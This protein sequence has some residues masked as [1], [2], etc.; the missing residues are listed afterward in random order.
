MKLNKLS[1]AVAASLAA[2]ASGTASAIDVYLTSA[3]ALRDTMSRMVS[4]YCTGAPG[5]FRVTE[6]DTGASSDKDFRVYECTFKPSSG[7]TGIPALGTGV[8]GNGTL[9]LGNAVMRIF[10][11]VKVD[12]SLGGSIVGVMPIYRPID[13]QFVTPAGVGALPAGCVALAN[14]TIGTKSWPKA[15]CNTKPRRAPNASDPGSG[16]NGGVHIG[17]SDTRTDNYVGLNLANVVQT[18][19][20]FLL[21]TP[22]EITH[23]STA[24]SP[25][26]LTAAP[27]VPFIQLGFGI[28]VTD[29]L[30]TATPALTNLSHSQIGSIFSGAVDNWTEVGGPNEPVT[31]CRRTQGSGTQASWNA[32]ANDYPCKANA[33]PF[34][35]LAVADQFSTGSGLHEGTGNHALEVIENAGT[36]DVKKCLNDAFDAGKMALGILSLENNESN[37]GAGKNWQFVALDGVQ[38]FD[39]GETFVNTVDGVV[40]RIR[41]ERMTLGNYNYSQEPTIQWRT[42]AVNGLP[43]APLAQKAFGIVLRDNA[44]TPGITTKLPGV[45]SLPKHASATVSCMTPTTGVSSMTRDGNVCQTLVRSSCL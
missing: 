3:T 19:G 39:E 1:L 30:F 24:L 27:P 28:A 8:G 4:E 10:H 29:N 5:T 43:P 18:P 36:G 15:K 38:L 9:D 42:A 45:V 13:M 41:E 22:D 32:M 23:W 44:G 40:D 37:L 35:A 34:G 25:T 26:E 11:T 2:S 20:L 21:D 17:V 14:E 12:A 6:F 16:N 33:S 7:P 31:I